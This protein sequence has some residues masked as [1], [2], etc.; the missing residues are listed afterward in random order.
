MRIVVRI[1]EDGPWGPAALSMSCPGRDAGVPHM[2][3]GAAVP[4]GDAWF[5]WGRKLLVSEL[6]GPSTA[7]PQWGEGSRDPRLHSSVHPHSSLALILDKVQLHL[8]TL[9]GP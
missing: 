3:R 4:P 2:G 9:P 8:L 1:R 5:L 7:R 6:Q